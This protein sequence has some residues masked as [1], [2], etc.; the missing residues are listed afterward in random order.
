MFVCGGFFLGGG[1]GL[2]TR[3]KEDHQWQME[4]VL[5]IT[6]ETRISIYSFHEYFIDDLF[7]LYLITFIVEGM[8]KAM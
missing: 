6:S 4:R 8:Y 5:R 7:L 1:W 2:E 3:S